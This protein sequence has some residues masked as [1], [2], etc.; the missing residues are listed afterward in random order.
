VDKKKH[1]F[2]IAFWTACGVFFLLLLL[3]TLIAVNR[4]SGVTGMDAGE[5]QKLRYDLNQKAIF[6]E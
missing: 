2:V 1:W 3:S 5:I 4:R 6:K